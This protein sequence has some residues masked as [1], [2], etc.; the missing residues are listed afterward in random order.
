VELTLLRLGGEITYTFTYNP[1]PFTTR[2]LSNTP[3]H[4]D[5]N[6]TYYE[7]GRKTAVPTTTRDGK[8]D[9]NGQV[10]DGS[11]INHQEANAKGT[12]SNK[13]SDFLSQNILEKDTKQTLT[14]N[15][16]TG[17]ACM[18]TETRTMTNATPD[19]KASPNYTIKLTSPIV[20]TARPA[21]KPKK[22]ATHRKPAN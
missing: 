4:E 16:P 17:A 1:P 15:S 20:Q 13:G 9:D 5:V 18:V 19:G 10:L 14:F 8:T 6:N 12:G 11:G 7:N 2:S 22:P 3:V 21:P